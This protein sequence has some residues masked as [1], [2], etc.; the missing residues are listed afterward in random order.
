MASLL[1]GMA[2]RMFLPLAACVLVELNRGA[3]S[4]AGFVHFVLAFYLIALP[5]DTL[6]AVTQIQP[7]KA[8]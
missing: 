7:T 6:L 3:L 8:A 5:L 2:V 1:L 4:D